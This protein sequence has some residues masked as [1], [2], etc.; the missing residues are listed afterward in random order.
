[1][2]KWWLKDLL[3]LI[4][5]LAVLVGANYVL[6]VLPIQGMAYYFRVIILIGISITLA[7]SL[8]I[9]NGHAGQFSLGHAGFMAIGAYLSAF[10]TYFYAVPYLETVPDGPNKLVLQNVLFLGALLF[11]GLCAAIAGYLVGLPSLRLRG[12]YLAIVTLGFGEII[13]VIFLNVDKLGGARGLSGVPA[14][15]NF[16]WV[17]FFAWMTVLVSMRL[18]K[19]SIGRAF[20]A[21]REDEI[22]AEAM[23][24]DTTRYKVQAFVIGSFFAGV[25]GGLYGHYLAYLN[26]AMFTF[27]KS[28]EVITMV[29]LGGLGSISGSIVAAIILTFL[30]EGL[31]M[32][33]EFLHMNSDPRMVIYSIL[34]IVLMLTRP[35]GLFGRREL[36][37]I[38]ARRKDTVPKETGD[39]DK[40]KM[41]RTSGPSINE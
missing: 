5:G 35:Q 28:F 12:D 23:G 18:I 7:V 39:E 30:P 4:V 31:R 41:D 33:K 22:A 25:A 9:I 29:V 36:W 11:G 16:I 8:N 14:W 10:V 17:Y 40:G 2:R 21:V 6:Q 20:L 13:R 32:A 15:S 27:M 24:V 3:L 19:S 38:L 37:E 1:M 34:L 26:P